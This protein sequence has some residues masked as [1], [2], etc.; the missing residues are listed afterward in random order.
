MSLYKKIALI[1]SIYD[2]G[3]IVDELSDRFGD[4]P[5]AAMNLVNI[6]YMKALASAIG[7][8]Q[9]RGD[10]SRMTFTIGEDD[11]NFEVWMEI[12]D[13]FERQVRLSVTGLETMQ[14]LIRDPENAIATI[15]KMFEKYLEILKSK[16]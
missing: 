2:V 11:F 9:I 1:R 7:I 16:R 14:A 10:K 3:D 8:K 13:L 4:P 6:A 15:N 12:S 5:P